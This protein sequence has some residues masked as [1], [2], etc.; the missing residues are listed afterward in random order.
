MDNLNNIL[1]RN[2]E[3]IKA[4][5]EIKTQAE[6]NRIQ[7]LGLTENLQT[8]FQPIL[9]SQEDI[10]KKLEPKQIQQSPV[11]SPYQIEYPIKDDE[12]II[13]S[14]Y[15]IN[16]YFSNPYPNLPKTISPIVDKKGLLFN[17]FRILFS[18]VYP[19]FEIDKKDFIFT[20]TEG[21]IDL[22]NDGDIEIAKRKDLVEYLKFL[23]MIKNKRKTKKD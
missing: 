14:L 13:R 12:I 18:N 9:K 4:K 2:K 20:T 1:K 15:D 7:Q 10:K 8:L 17:G 21:L 22:M 6:N 16:H 3:Y 19:L 11:P 23:Y 5:N